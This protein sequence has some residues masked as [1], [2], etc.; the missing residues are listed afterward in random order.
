MFKLS[1]FDQIQRNQAINRMEER[2]RAPMRYGPVRRVTR[3][4]KLHKQVMFCFYPN[5]FFFFFFII[6]IIGAHG[7]TS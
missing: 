3:Y 7:V 6:I 5:T 2:R 1:V 4:H